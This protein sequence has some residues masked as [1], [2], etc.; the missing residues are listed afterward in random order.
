MTDYRTLHEIQATMDTTAKHIERQAEQ[1]PPNKHAL[2][3]TAKGWRDAAAYVRAAM[4]KES[5]GL[6]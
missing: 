5:T 1:D 4:G 2:L 6:A 3:A